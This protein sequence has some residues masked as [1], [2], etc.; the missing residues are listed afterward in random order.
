[1]TLDGLVLTWRPLVL[2]KKQMAAPDEASA[3][4]GLNRTGKPESIH[5]VL[6]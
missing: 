1:V 3:L 4:A 5:V 2:L 6:F